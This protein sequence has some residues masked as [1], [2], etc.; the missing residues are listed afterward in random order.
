MLDHAIFAFVQ[1]RTS[2]I[3]RHNRMN[4]D[5]DAPQF[6]IFLRS[7]GLFRT[8]IDVSE[9]IW[10]SCRCSVASCRAS[11][12]G[13]VVLAVTVSASVQVYTPSTRTSIE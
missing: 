13:A 6:C 4:A 9:K 11:C 2:I 12:M 5:A 10:N 7:D 3:E 8:E 1:E